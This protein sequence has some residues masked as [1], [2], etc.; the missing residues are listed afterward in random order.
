MEPRNFGIS[1]VDTQ[2]SFLEDSVNSISRNGCPP[3]AP[4]VQSSKLV[5]TLCQELYF[6]MV[7]AGC[8]E[9]ICLSWPEQWKA[10]LNEQFIHNSFA[11]L[12]ITAVL[13]CFTCRLPDSEHASLW[14]RLQ[15]TN[16]KSFHL[17]LKKRW[18]LESIAS[19]CLRCHA[20]SDAYIDF[21]LEL[22]CRRSSCFLRVT[23]SRAI[24]ELAIGVTQICGLGSL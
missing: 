14:A 7:D 22:L 4:A 5:L 19:H 3:N 23:H 20:H 17:K 1:E 2:V 21:H 15:F 11:F 13:I 18:L 12:G 8:G 10:W 24:K 16:R 9:N 6:P